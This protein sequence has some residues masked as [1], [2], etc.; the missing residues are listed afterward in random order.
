MFALL[1]TADC[2]LRC[3]AAEQH[4]KTNKS[5]L[6]RKDTRPAG[7]RLR[8]FW[9]QLGRKTL[10]LLITSVFVYLMNLY[11]LPLPARRGM[12]APA[13]AALLLPRPYDL[14]RDGVDQTDGRERAADDRADAVTVVPAFTGNRTATAMG[15]RS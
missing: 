8:A 7:L 13:A 11:A 1:N 12:A 15:L 3:K 5:H 2:I 9:H 14:V 6:S 10:A 4:S